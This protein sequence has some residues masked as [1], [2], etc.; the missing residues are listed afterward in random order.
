MAAQVDIPKQVNGFV[1]A[2]FAGKKPTTDLHTHVKANG[3]ASV[4]INGNA[5]HA[6]DPFEIS[7]QYAYT[8]RKLKV[9]TI[10]AGFSGLLM[11]HKF[12]HR[13][14]DMKDIVEHTIFD[15]R[16]DIGGTWLANHYP[17]GK[18]QVSMSRRNLTLRLFLRSNL[19]QCDVPAHIYVSNAW[20]L[21][22]ST[23][24]DRLD[25]IQAFPFDPNPDWE[26]FYASGGDIL[27]YMKATVKKWGLDR[28]LQLNTRV[29]GAWWQDDRGQWKVTVEHDG[30]QRDEYCHVL[31]SAQGVLV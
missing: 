27:A 8:P 4:H 28:D 31:I 25:Q 19:V 30:V 2:E 7:K 29:V 24:V 21:P 6:M 15:M 13:F 11:A 10:G 5:T 16:S 14:P 22:R 26:R 18:K 1:K 23:G 17:G 9:F 3:S 12:Q 20:Q